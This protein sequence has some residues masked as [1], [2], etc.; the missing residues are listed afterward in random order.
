[1]A[2]TYN[3]DPSRSP[4]DA[5][6]FYIG[7][8]NSKDVQ[9]QDGEIEFVL[10][11]F[12]NSATNAAVRCCEAIIAKLSSLTDEKVG[13]VDIK[14]SQRVDH[15]QKML[16]NLRTRVAVTDT[17][18]FAGGISR[19][20]KQANVQNTDLVRPD[21]TKR[22]MENHQNSSLEPQDEGT[23]NNAEDG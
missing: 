20:Q 14:F 6:R 11:Q 1:M 19:S 7:D 21:F 3:G 8:T 15:Y 5:V 12:N 2:F 9:L 23:N 22:M 17:V 4:L 10:A 16:A 18:P 13:Q